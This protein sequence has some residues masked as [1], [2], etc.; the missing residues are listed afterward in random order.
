MVF[1]PAI[2]MAEI[3]AQIDK[4]YAVQQHNEFGKE[5][6]A[7]LFLP[8][9]YKLNVP[10]GFYTQALGLGNSPDSVHIA[11]NVHVDAASRNDNATFWRSAEGFS[12]TPVGGTM[13]WALMACMAARSAGDSL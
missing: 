5:R 6:N 4:V 3:Q 11:G 13:Q 12:V 7:F 9:E 2:P 1:S 10:I 8:G